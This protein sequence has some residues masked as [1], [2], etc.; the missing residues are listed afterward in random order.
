M[1][2][3]R[4]SK[5]VVVGYKYFMGV[6]LI[7]CRGPV[8]AIRRINIGER[9]AWSGEVT[10]SS[11]ISINKPSLFGGDSREG[12][13]VGNVLVRMGEITQTVDPYLAQFQGSDTSAYRGLLSIIFSNF[14]WSSGNPYFKAPAIEVTRILKDWPNDDPWYPSKAVINTLDMNPAHILYQVLT[15]AAV[16]LGYSRLEMSDV[17]W[18]AAADTLHDEGFGLSMKLIQF[19]QAEDFVQIVLDHINGAINTNLETGLLEIDLIRGDYDTGSLLELNPDNILE[20]QSF[21]RASVEDLVNTITIVYRDRNGKRKPITQSNNAMV[22]T[23]GRIIPATREYEGIREDDLASRVLARDLKTLSTPLASMRV[24]TNRVLWNR[25]KGEVVRLVYPDL[26]IVGVPFRIAEIDLGSQANGQITA[27]LAED[28]FGLPERG[29]ANAPQTEWIDT[30][31]PPVKADATRV[32][33]APYRSVITMISS[34]DREFLE[35][36][37]GFG[38]MLASR[39]AVQTPTGYTLASSSDNVSY[40]DVAVGQ[41]NPNGFSMGTINKL[42]TEIVLTGAMDLLEVELSNDTGGG[43]LLINNELMRVD[44]VDSSTGQVEVGRGILDTVPAT[45]PPASRVYFITSGTAVDPN[46][47]V[48]AEQVYYKARPSTGIGT[49]PLQDADEVTLTFNNRASRP[50]PPG[51]FVIDDNTQYPPVIPGPNVIIEWA[52]RNRLDQT[53]YYVDSSESSVAP[54]PDSF[55]R[56]RVYQ[57][58]PPEL[59]RTYDVSNEFN[60]WAYP[61]ED[62]DEDGNLSVLRI[63]VNSVIGELESLQA[64]EHTFQRSVVSGGIV[65]DR[66]PAR[67]T[68]S[69]V[70]TMGGANLTVAP[71]DLRTNIEKFEILVSLTPNMSDATVLQYLD[72]PTT[73]FFAPLPDQRFRWFWVR[74]NDDAGILSEWSIAASAR[75]ENLD[76]YGILNEINAILSSDDTTD[77]IR[78]LADKFVIQSPDGTQTPFALV[79]MPDDS[80]KLL[81]NSDVLI[82]GNVDIANLTTGS[83]PNDVMMRLGNGI[84]ELDGAGEIRVFKSTDPDS[85][86][87]RLSSGEIRF[88]RYVDG[89]YVTYNFLSRAESGVAANGAL[90]EIPGYW[91]QPPK[92]IVSPANITLFK[93]SYNTQDQAI[94]CEADAIQETVPGSGRYQFV[95]RAMLTLAAAVGSVTTSASSG[96]TGGNWTSAAFTTPANT[97][98]VT[99]SVRLKSQRGNGVSQYYYRTGTWSLEYYNGSTWV[100]AFTR[101]IPIGGQFDYV[102]DSAS[103][104]LPSA[105]AWQIRISTSYT[106]TN[107][108]VFGAP[109]Y[110]YSDELVTSNTPLPSSATAQGTGS[111]NATFTA[112]NTLGFSAPVQPGEIYRIDYL[113]VNWSATANNGG[114]AATFQTTHTGALIN[115]G[116]GIVFFNR[117]GVTQSTSNSFNGSASNQTLTVNGSNI[118]NANLTIRATVNQSRPAYPITTTFGIGGA[119]NII[120]ARVYHRIPIPN[121]TTPVN[122]S[123]FDKFDYLLAS[124]VTLASGTLNWQAIGE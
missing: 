66:G 29:Y 34:A 57:V 114:G 90:V 11:T 15:D 23:Q 104:D 3:K 79:Q 111:S 118:P 13:V 18:R 110:T 61:T 10:A 97:S 67:P 55:Y 80:Y 123:V 45:H 46:E 58:T 2:S 82:G 37:Y 68:I 93:A 87:V 44:S 54:E 25:K 86:F 71:G 51:R 16:G 119:G 4:S 35:A 84:I 91:N 64:L 95:P 103:F 124:A 70:G 63:T 53:S 8:D 6:Q 62:D 69:A 30:L 65:I 42:T 121:S 43:M 81:L 27:V 96:D 94:V 100:V 116:S 73:T 59:L 39:G 109:S 38:M 101:S 88:L 72:Y 102:T 75:A 117:S 14:Q 21:Q 12:G 50:Y 113:G 33:E 41:F 48:A 77:S 47:H 85:D 9:E 99:P 115:T 26:G 107:G 98:R 120:Q 40:D 60:S 56:V 7:P 74:V 49:L 92:I 122:N 108:T 24:V 32:L 105:A 19:D 1:G 112:T 52:H 78:M 22:R 28:V 83:L 31:L 89:A 106:D 76:V 20:M 5:K 36:D 17:S